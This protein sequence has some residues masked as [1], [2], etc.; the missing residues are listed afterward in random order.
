MCSTAQ[1]LEI[2]LRT[3]ANTHKH[4]RKDSFSQRLLV[5]K[6]VRS[7]K[8]FLYTGCFAYSTRTMAVWKGQA[9]CVAGKPDRCLCKRVVAW[10]L[11]LKDLKGRLAFCV[12]SVCVR[13][14]PMP[15]KSCKHV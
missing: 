1:K 11:S 8:E 4:S 12:E 6:E 3:R 10:A 15:A 7:A 13:G 14:A 9:L 2:W 5:Q